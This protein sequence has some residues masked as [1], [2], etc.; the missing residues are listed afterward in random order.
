MTTSSTFDLLLERVSAGERLG[1]D[2]LAHLAATPDILQLGMLADTVR[3]ALHG[4]QVTYLR[5]AL[6]PFDQPF[7]DAE[8]R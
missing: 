8:C 2:D 6:C 5:V 4:S 3:R 1:E 7:T